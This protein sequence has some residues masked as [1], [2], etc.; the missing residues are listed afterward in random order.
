MITI[1]VANL[2][3]GV[4]KSTTAANLAAVLNSMGKK[5]LLLDLDP[6]G[7]CSDSYKAIST[8]VA[9]MYDVLLDYD[10]P[11]PISEAIQHTDV[12]DIVA[13]D[14]A[15]EESDRLFRCDGSSEF[16][17]L[18]NALQD[19][20]GY[21]FAIID[22]G[23]SVSILVENALSAADYVVIP[24]TP[25]RYS[26][27]GIMAMTRLIQR[28]KQRNPNLQTAGYLMTMCHQ[29]YST[30][31]ETREALEN[32][33]QQTGTRVFQTCI[34][35]CQQVVKAQTARTNV[36]QYDP[37]CN[38]AHDYKDFAGEL[39]HILGEGEKK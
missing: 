28:Q 35:D 10:D 34:R 31:R 19:V 33:A 20:K 12:G 7:N 3:G 26:L 8:D 6:S 14:P 2:K 24:I 18:R 13:S 38:A 15:L 9:T 4:G 29:R 25:A 5:T 11:C 27:A 17:R 39:L 37:R 32:V 16:L 21:D 36:I 22:S 1:S 30:T 23:P